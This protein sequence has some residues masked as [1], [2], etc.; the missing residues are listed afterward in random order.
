MQDTV[1]ISA[2][3]YDILPNFNLFKSRYF[4]SIFQ[5]L[6]LCTIFLYIIVS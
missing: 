1:Y 4:R 3:F 2:T 6:F 5:S